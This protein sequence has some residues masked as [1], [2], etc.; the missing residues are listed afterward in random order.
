MTE[1]RP[2]RLYD[3]VREADGQYHCYARAANVNHLFR[4]TGGW[5]WHT[6]HPV[7]FPTEREARQFCKAHAEE[8][9]QKSER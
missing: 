2:K 9:R 5:H 7:G 1:T 4:P 6:I 3:V 8:A